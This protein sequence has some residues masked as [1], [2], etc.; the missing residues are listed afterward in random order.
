MK[1]RAVGWVAIGVG[2]VA[3]AVVA[4]DIAG[5]PFLRAPLQHVASNATGVPVDMSGRFRLH[6][7]WNPRVSFEAL[8]VGAAPPFAPKPLLDAKGLV[9]RW[10]WPDLWRWHRGGALHLRELRAT[11]LQANLLR[12]ADGRASWQF[13]AGPPAAVN[14]AKTAQPWPSVALLAVDDGQIHIDDAVSDAHV[15]VT[16]RGHDGSDGSGQSG[17]MAYEAIAKGEYGKLP[18]DLRVE[19]GGLLP[20]LGGDAAAAKVDVPIRVVGSVGQAKLKFDGRVGAITDDARLGGDVSLQAVSMADVGDVIGVTL[21]RTPPFKLSGRLQH[22]GAVWKLDDMKAAVGASR[23][24]GDFRF[25]TASKPPKLTGKMTGSLLRL[26]DLGPAIGAAGSVKVEARKSSAHVLPQREFDLP[27]L[28]AMDADVV[29]DIDKLDFGTDMLRPFENVRTHLLLAGGVL[30]LNDLQ[31]DVAGGQVSGKSSLDGTGKKANWSADLN[32]KG[33]EISQWI[34]GVRKSPE[35]A[36]PPAASPPVESGGATRTEP[37]RPIAGGGAP[38]QPI[39]RG[40]DAKR[41]AAASAPSAPARGADAAQQ[42]Y[43]SGDLVGNVDVKGSGRSTAQILASLDGTARMQLRHGSVSHLVTELAGLDLAQSLGVAVAGDEPL[44]LNCAKLDVAI[45][46][47]IAVPRVAV[48]DNSDSTIRMS[49]QIDLRNETLDLKTVTHPKDFSPLSLRSPL[50]VT[51]TLGDP[52]VDIGGKKVLALRA[53]AAVALGVVATPAAAVLP[54]ID[55]GDAEKGDPCAP[56]PAR[57]A[58]SAPR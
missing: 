3:V 12:Q 55:P 58:A 45:K 11:Q 5:W 25:D 30:H 37:R 33:L 6:L 19:S 21:P 54:F 22:D 27:S 42:A 13:G 56:H 39:A 47:G 57:A 29:F 51:G 44:K 2:A 4:C 26:A 14:A 9:V 49:G 43:L 35:V 8:R 1:L 50:K 17:V 40:D 48:L 18:I 16:L 31:A 41:S 52:Q 46:N 24:G 28:S 23:L 36:K 10:S 15:D 53:L 38:Q 34:V 7:L 20:M 32:F